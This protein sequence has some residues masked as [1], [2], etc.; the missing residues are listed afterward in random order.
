MKITNEENIGGILRQAGTVNQLKSKRADEM[1]RAFLHE[2][3][4]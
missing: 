1:V 4:Q 2:L 3:P